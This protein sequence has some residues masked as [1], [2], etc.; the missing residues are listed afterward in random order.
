MTIF[1]RASPPRIHFDFRVVPH[2]L[3]GLVDHRRK[4]GFVGHLGIRHS[5]VLPEFRGDLQNRR[6][7]HNG[8][9]GSLERSDEVAQLTDHQ[10]RARSPVIQEE[11]EVFQDEQS[12]FVELRQIGRDAMTA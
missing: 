3:D 2:L 7:N 12:G 5:H 8:L 1:A 9:P 10:S 11:M 6:E 4:L